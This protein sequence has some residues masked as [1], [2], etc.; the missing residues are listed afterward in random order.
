MVVVGKHV[1]LFLHFAYCGVVVEIQF[2]L[3]A[4]I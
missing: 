1:F 4:K 2:H 3:T